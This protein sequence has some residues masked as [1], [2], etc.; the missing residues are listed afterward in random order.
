MDT[1]LYRWNSFRLLLI[2]SIQRFISPWWRVVGGCRN[3][4]Y[5]SNPPLKI[6]SCEW[7]LICNI[8]LSTQSHWNFAQGTAVLLPCPVQHFKVIRQSILSHLQ[9]W[10]SEFYIKKWVNP[11]IVTAPGLLPWYIAV[12]LESW[13][14]YSHTHMQARRQPICLLRWP[15]GIITTRCAD[16]TRWNG[17]CEKIGGHV[18]VM[19]WKRFPHYWPF[20]RGSPSQWWISLK[21]TNTA[22]LWCFCFAEP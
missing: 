12:L 19:V 5:P 13:H 14:V 10:F 22:A 1:D 17:L 6:K 11:F 7:Y 18:D 20:A 15:P 8:H 4:G 2:R 3:M 9:T 16:L 21:I